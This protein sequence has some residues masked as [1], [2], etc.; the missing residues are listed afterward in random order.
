MSIKQQL[1]K[2]H[3]HLDQTRHK[4]A[5]AEK[6]RDNAATLRLKLEIESLEQ[7]I[8]DAKQ[9]QQKQVNHQGSE[10]KNL[11]FSRPLTKAEQG[12]LGK[13]KK[14]I[15]GLVV[16]HPLTVLGREMGLT[17]VTGFAKAEF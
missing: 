15:R 5:T 11:P 2:L 14:S 4:L 16:V 6:G 8:I 10:V 13:L 7:R 17:Q 1:Q 9:K 12:D 3:D